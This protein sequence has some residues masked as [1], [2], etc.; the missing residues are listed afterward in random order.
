MDGCFHHSFT[1]A[2]WVAGGGDDGGGAGHGRGGSGDCG[3]GAAHQVHHGLKCFRV[4]YGDGLR[5]WATDRAAAVGVARTL[6]VLVGV[7]VVI[8]FV[9]V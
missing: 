2:R 4:E 6:R 8:V 7:V 3:G 9:V 1:T 5:G